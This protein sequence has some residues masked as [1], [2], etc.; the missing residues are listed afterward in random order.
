MLIEHMQMYLNS[1]FDPESEESISNVYRCYFWMAYGG[2]NENDAIR[3]RTSDVDMSDMVFRIGYDEFPIYR[4]AIKSFNNCVK[5]DSFKYMHPNYKKDV[6][7]PRMGGDLLL[8][9]IKTDIS[10]KS[11]RVAI[12]QKIKAAYNNGAT[13]I[14]MSYQRAMMSGIFYRVYQLE[15]IGIE[16]DFMDVA[17]DYIKGREYNLSSG[18]NLIGARQRKIAKD[19]MND[20]I[21]WKQTFIK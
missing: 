5:L 14:K 9:G 15:L 20:Y 21:K 19:Y 13:T 16:P 12:N 4:E 18:R 3:V 1:V 8:R 6:Y 11:F 10:I 7:I 17:A 2:C